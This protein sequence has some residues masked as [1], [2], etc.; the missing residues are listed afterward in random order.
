MSKTNGTSIEWGDFNRP[1]NAGVSQS[2][3]Y[4]QTGA[5]ARAAFRSASNTERTAK[6]EAVSAVI[7]RSDGLAAGSH[8]L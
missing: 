3:L 6:F 5:R 1:P 7:S 4:I 2:K 8:R